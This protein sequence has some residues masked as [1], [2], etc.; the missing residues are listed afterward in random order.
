[1]MIVSSTSGD[2]DD[3]ESRDS[4][5]ELIF[6]TESLLLMAE[7]PGNSGPPS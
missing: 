7:L 2:I 4:L 6:R 1:M 5:K 3:R